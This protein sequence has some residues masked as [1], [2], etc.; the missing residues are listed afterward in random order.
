MTK[1]K[2]WLLFVL[3][4]STGW[5]VVTLIGDIANQATDIFSVLQV[6]LLIWT[7]IAVKSFYEEVYK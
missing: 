2:F 4:M 3:G 1:Q 5:T 6:G 7:A